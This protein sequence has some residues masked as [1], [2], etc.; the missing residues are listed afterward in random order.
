MKKILL[1]LIM[2][3]TFGYSLPQFGIIGVS[4]GGAGA[5]IFEENYSAAVL[6]ST[7]N[8][9]DGVEG[10]DQTNLE[11]NVKYKH[12]LDKL[13]KL[14][15]G[16]KYTLITTDTSSD[17]DSDESTLMAF[18]IGIERELASNLS[19]FG[20]TD[21]VSIMD[22]DDGETETAVFNTARVGFIYKF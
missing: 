10:E 22:I 17:D 1:L 6:F 7:V 8:N 21:V 9:K 19:I 5:G 13:T 12:G 20:E 15:L 11:F 14:L 2:M 4:D 3:A 18:S 16:G